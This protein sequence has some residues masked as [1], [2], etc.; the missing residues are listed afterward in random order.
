VTKDRAKYI[1]EGIDAS[2]SIFE[3]LDMSICRELRDSLNIAFRDR[4]SLALRTIGY[5]VEVLLNERILEGTNVFRYL[6]EIDNG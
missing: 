4:N 6:E 5:E 2:I 3:A 1:K